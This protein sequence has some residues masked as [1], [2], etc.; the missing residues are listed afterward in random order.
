M[1]IAIKSNTQ[2]TYI[3]YGI[4]WPTFSDSLKT[5][6]YVIDSNDGFSGF[7]VFT[8]DEIVILDAS[9]DHYSIVKDGYGKDMIVHNAAHPSE[10]F[11][12]ALVNHDS[13]D[14]IEELLKN[15]GNLGLE[16]LHG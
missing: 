11:F 8:E 10:E 15:M 1:K 12:D 2:K 5:H 13:Y 3:P 16:I 9:L 4:Y 7:S 6:Y 14:N